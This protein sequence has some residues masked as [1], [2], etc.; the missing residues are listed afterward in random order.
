MANLGCRVNVKGDDMSLSFALI[1]VSP[2]HS[3]GRADRAIFQHSDVRNL[4]SG[5]GNRQLTEDVEFGSLVF[6][7]T[8]NKQMA[9]YPMTYLPHLAIWRMM[10]A[11][12]YFFTPLPNVKCYSSGRNWPRFRIDQHH[13]PNEVL[14]LD[15]YSV[16]LFY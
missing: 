14:F 2:K 16:A 9:S 11:D 12:V 4:V 15:I 1:S 13:C 7:G 5:Q 3:V 6:V 8:G 10:I